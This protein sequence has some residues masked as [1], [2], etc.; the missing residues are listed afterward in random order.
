M[1]TELWQNGKR[2]KHNTFYGGI[3][4]MPEVVT[5]GETMVMFSPGQ[6]VPLSYVHS[7]HKR[8]A[9][10]E[11]NVA[12][13]LVRLGHSCGWISRVGKD[14]FGRFILRELR[15][16][17]VDVSRVKTVETAPTGVMFKEILEGRETNV[18]YYRQNSAASGMAPGDLELDY[19]GGARILHLTGITPALGR[20]CLETVLEA[21][22]FAHSRG[23]T[24][25]F[26]PNIRLKLW[27]R[28]EAGKVIKE[29]L[30]M[31]DIV[32]PGIDEGEIIFGTRSQEEVIDAFLSCGVKVVA[33]KLGAKGALAAKGSERHFVEGFKV[34]HAVDPIG[35][36]DAFA[37][38]FLAGYLEGKEPAE[39]A[40]L[41]NAMGAL[42]V[43]SSGDIEGLP[44]RSKLE[45]FMED[46]PVVSR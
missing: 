41:A 43:T 23:V 40:R 17:G 31:V 21:V 14:E 42:A 9:G 16:E 18:Y 12:V 13:G 1:K 28:E 29:L 5:I 36:G 34:E 22:S 20:S 45:A 46:R 32:L 26:D 38:G 35:A 25:S 6:N 8:I 33:L 30:P 15:G 2:V 39:C 4:S 10:A 44:E 24:V 3:A 11:S 27:S 37:A 19:I 7:F